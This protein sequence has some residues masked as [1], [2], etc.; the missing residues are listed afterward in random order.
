MLKRCG[1]APGRLRAANRPFLD[2]VRPLR[3]VAAP[4]H[5]LLYDGEC[6]FCHRGVSFVLRH[7]KRDRFRFAPLQSRAGRAWVAR[8]GDDPDDIATVRI[9]VDHEGPA[10]RMLTRGRAGVF[11]LDQLG[12]AWRAG[13]ALR[14]LPTAL[15]DWGYGLVARNRHRLA[16]DACPLPPP[17]A[18]WKFV[19][20]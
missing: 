5:L 19:D 10:P 11:I 12:G 2:P 4:T 1:P 20:A 3:R 18:R 14:V 15:L 17:E 6:G 13:N 9:V 7:D 8:F 16:G